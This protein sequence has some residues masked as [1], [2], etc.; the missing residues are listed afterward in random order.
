MDNVKPVTDAPAPAIAPAIAPAPA[1]DAI[2]P[3]NDPTPTNLSKT[4]PEDFDGNVGTD[5][6][7]P[8]KETI[9]KVAEYRLQDKHGKLTPFKDLY[10]GSGQKRRVLVIFIRHF[11]CGVSLSIFLSL[12]ETSVI[13][14]RLFQDGLCN[15]D[16]TEDGSHAATCREPLTNDLCRIVRNTSARLPHPSHQSPSRLSP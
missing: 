9:A 3:A 6:E 10:R 11:Y 5:D 12:S 16:G 1:T 2:T 13:S 7:I 8:S 15:L 14:S 4:R